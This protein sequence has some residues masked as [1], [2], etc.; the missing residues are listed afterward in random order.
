[1]KQVRHFL[2]SKDYLVFRLTGCFSMDYAS[3]TATLMFDVKKKAWSNTLSVLAGLADDVLPPLFDPTEVV[4][5]ISRESADFFGLPEG[6]PVISGTLDSAAEMLGC[7]ILNP[8]E[9]GMV[10]LGSA[11]GIMVVTERPA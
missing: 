4:G 5:R 9:L 6:V 7:G 2:S 8:G 3:A 1:M 10:R 11:G